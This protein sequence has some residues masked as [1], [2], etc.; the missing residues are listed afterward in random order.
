MSAR[1]QAVHKWNDTKIGLVAGYEYEF[2]T[3]GDK[4]YPSG[5]DGYVS[6]SLFL[7]ACERLRRDP[8]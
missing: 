2:R 7:R 3:S 4:H 8:D 5:P 1:V 6:A